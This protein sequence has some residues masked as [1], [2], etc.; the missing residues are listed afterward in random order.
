[1][2]KKTYENPESELIAVRFE[3]NLMASE[4]EVKQLQE[5]NSSWWDDDEE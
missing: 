5:G 3:E 4:F 1:M 2:I